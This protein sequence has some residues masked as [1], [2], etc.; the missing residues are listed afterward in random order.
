ML[1]ILVMSFVPGPLNGGNEGEMYVYVLIM[2]A[3]TLT[4]ASTI[5]IS[6]SFHIIAHV[7]MSVLP[8]AI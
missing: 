3:H 1:I 7:F 2:N 5:E 8:T 6:L 4:H